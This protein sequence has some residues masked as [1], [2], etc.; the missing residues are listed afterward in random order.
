MLLPAAPLLPRH[1]HGLLDEDGATARG[2]PCRTAQHDQRMQR[3]LAAILDVDPTVVL[4]AVITQSQLPARNGGLA[5]ISMEHLACTA[6]LA[7]ACIQPCDELPSSTA[8]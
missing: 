8:P 4:P 6:F 2:S 1:T 7:C 3:T 5:L